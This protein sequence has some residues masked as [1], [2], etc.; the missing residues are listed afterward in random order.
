MTKTTR[1]PLAALASFFAAAIFLGPVS[2]HA[3]GEAKS[4][5][6]F[7]DWVAYQFTEDGNKV[8]YMASAPK[9]HVEGGAKRGEIFA[10]VTNRPAE[11]SKNVFSYIAGYTYKPG[12]EVS[13]TIGDQKFSLFTQDDTAW[14]ADAATDAKIAEALRK[15]SGFVVKG[16]SSR[17]TAT[18]DTFSLKGSGSAHD[19]IN[20]ECGTP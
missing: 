11:G 6:T 18:T 17:G 10:L 14:A 9:K 2:A 12:S 1:L 15:G 20:K 4:I 13:L 16:T 19:A 3:A 8:C 5:G 7:N